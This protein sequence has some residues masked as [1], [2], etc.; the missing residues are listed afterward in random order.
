MKKQVI[1]L[2]PVLATVLGVVACTPKNED[3]QAAPAA[4]ASAQ[5][6][7]ESKQAPAPVCV[8]PQAQLL[9]VSEFENAEFTDLSGLKLQR[10]S[11]VSNEGNPFLDIKIDSKYVPVS[12]DIE[13]YLSSSGRMNIELV[14]EIINKYHSLVNS[15]IEECGTKIDGRDFLALSERKK[16]AM[17]F[18]E[19]INA[20]IEKIKQADAEEAEEAAQV[21]A[22]DAKRAEEN[23]AEYS[24][25]EQQ[26]LADDEAPVNTEK[27]KVS[28]SPFG[29]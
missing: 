29:N 11:I 25:D 28:T 21:A 18:L 5:A 13:G 9:A 23:D 6:A 17:D 27:A 14:S 22:E 12:F 15:A 8:D 3:K 19:V 16:A 20:E 7:G 26:Y 24:D 2:A 10:S 1:Y 4:K